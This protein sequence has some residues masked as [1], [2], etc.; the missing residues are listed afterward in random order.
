[1]RRFVGTVAVVGTVLVFLS[2]ALPAYAAAGDLDPTFGVGGKLTTEFSSKEGFVNTVVWQTDGKLVSAGESGAS[3]SNPKLAL[4]RHNADGSLDTTFGGDGEVTTDF[5]SKEDFA[6]AL[7]IQSDGKIVAVGEAGGGGPNPK[8][9]V[10]RYNAD[11]SLDTSFS[12][13]GKLTTDFSQGEDLAWIVA[14]QAD[15][16]IV[17]GGDALGGNPTWALARYNTDGSLDTSFGGDG[18]VTTNFTSYPEDLLALAI[19]PDGKILAA[20]GSGYGDPDE[21]FVLARYN[22]DGS[23][24]M[25]FGTGGKVTTSFTRHPDV[26]FSM[27]I[28]AG[29]IVVAGQASLAFRPTFA[30]ARYNPDGS[31]DTGFGGDGKAT[32]DFTRGGDDGAYSMAFQADGKIVAAG[33]AGGKN[34]NWKFALV[35]Y[36]TDG[37][38]DTSFGGDGKVTTDFTDGYEAAY[39]VA[40]QPDG[41]IVAAGPSGPEVAVARYLAA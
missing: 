16:K 14:V 26:A 21:N 18:T 35:R 38:L 9:A 4:A 30:L 3:E 2:F 24:D 22:A 23:L 5:T 19:Q 8:F 10:A 7:A 37:S 6:T 36:N 15:G 33:Q 17:A 39:N 1:M 32:T 20:G 13:D 11:G 29:K 34:Y 28:Q 31:L 12:A 27:S 25:S 41:K 40:I